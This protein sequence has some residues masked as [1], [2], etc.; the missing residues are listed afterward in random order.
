MKGRE[1][2]TARK[3]VKFHKSTFI[4]FARNT[5]DDKTVSLE[6][7]PKGTEFRRKRKTN[8]IM[9]KKKATGIDENCSWI[10]QV[11]AK[12]VSVLSHS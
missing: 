8:L 12:E 1:K 9:N 6:T 10:P 4:L 3:Y 5:L 11:C 2:V 7:N